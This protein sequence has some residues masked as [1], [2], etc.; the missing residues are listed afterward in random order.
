MVSEWSG[1]SVIH[2]LGFFI[3]FLIYRYMKCDKKTIKRTFSMFYTMINNGF[4]TN[5]S[6]HRVLFIL[7]KQVNVAFPKITD[8]IP[9][10]F[11][12]LCLPI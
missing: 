9:Q 2:G 8:Q 1:V 4:L 5:Q 7:S 10:I 11:F 12:T 6:A 3:C